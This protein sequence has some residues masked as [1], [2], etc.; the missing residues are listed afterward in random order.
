MSPPP[1][2]GRLLQADHFGVEAAKSLD[3]HG[4]SLLEVLAV[5]P[6]PEA[7][8]EQVEAH[9]AQGRGESA[10]DTGHASTSRRPQQ[11]R[12]R[13]HRMNPFVHTVYSGTSGT[14]ELA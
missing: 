2:R 3:R 12:T 6:E 1:S 14:L 4:E 11:T 13:A 5:A 9:D 10:P 8:V 7:T